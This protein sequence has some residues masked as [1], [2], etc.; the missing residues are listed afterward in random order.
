MSTDSARRWQQFGL[1]T[2]CYL[3]WAGLSALALWTTLQLL[4]TISG[5]YTYYRVNV[6]GVP[7]D[8]TV[9]TAYQITTAN[10][11][12]VLVFVLVWLVGVVVLEGYLRHAT[13][14]GRLWSRSARILAGLLIL[15]GVA[16]IPRLVL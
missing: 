6:V 9:D 4:T 3:I 1:Y 7:R 16:Y 14:E 10:Q 2:A 15:L 5:A 13:A 8:R 12:L 11:F